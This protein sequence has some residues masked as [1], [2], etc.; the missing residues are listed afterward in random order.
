M[1][2]FVEAYSGAKIRIPD[3][4]GNCITQLPAFFT[5]ILLGKSTNPLVNEIADKVPLKGIKNIVFLLVDGFGT[6]Q[7]ESHKANLTALQKFESNG[8]LSYLDSVFPASTPPALTTLHTNGLTPAQHGLIDWWLYIEEADK[9][10]ATLPFSEMGMEGRDSLLSD[11]VS[12][13]ILVNTKTTAEKMAEL[14]IKTRVFSLKDY[15]QSTY[16]KVSNKG[17]EFIPHTNVDE[18]F[19][20]L[21][22]LLDKSQTTPTFN[23]VYWG[24]IDSVGHQY[25]PEGADYDRAV[26]QYFN[27]LDDFLGRTRGKEDTLFVL[28]ADHGQI[29]VNPKETIYLDAIAGLHGLFKVSPAG[30]TILPWGGPREVFIAIKDNL[31][32]KT[33]SL[34]DEAIGDQV[35]LL[36][37]RMALEA[38]L[39]GPSSD[40]HPHIESR[41]GDVIV[42]PK[43]YKTVWYHHPG[44]K[45]FDMNGHHGGLSDDELKVPFALLRST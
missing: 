27:A 35:E 43:Y 10:I 32:K 40:R 22:E 39:F 18:L 11:G 16:T 4:N 13:S 42:L 34:I 2:D 45:P 7:W 3:Y 21:S 9:I 14:G 25:G 31:H 8:S 37:S 28:S 6:K 12:P 1:T 17:S 33:L 30:K 38:G 24:G 19:K 26:N 36:D 15:N 20:T 41:L 44:Q 23:F 5:D 29:R